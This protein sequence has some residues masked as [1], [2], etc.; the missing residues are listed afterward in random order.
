MQF[1]SYLSFDGNC[2]EAFALYAKVFGAEVTEQYT[3]AEMPDESDLPSLSDDDRKKIMHA[4]LKS[5]D[6]CLFGSDSLPGFCEGGAYQQPQGVSTAVVLE[7]LAEAER[8]FAALAE[9]G[10]VSMRFGQTFFAAGFGQVRD[11]F[12]VPWMVTVW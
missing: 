10:A 12:G 5:D 1:I 7:D 2:A 4:T 8:V 9:G 3:F 11:R 6:L